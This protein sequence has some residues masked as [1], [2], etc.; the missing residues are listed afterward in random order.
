MELI[1]YIGRKVKIILN[2]DYYF[3][4]KVVSAD[5]NSLDLIDFKNQNVSLT[6]DSI[7]SIQEVGQ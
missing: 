7:S 1:N 6:K 3:I 4:G 5:E 2:N